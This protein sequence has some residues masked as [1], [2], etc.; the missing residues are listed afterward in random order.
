M[1]LSDASSLIHGCSMMNIKIQKFQLE[2]RRS[3]LKYNFNANQ[4][5]LEAIIKIKYVILLIIIAN[6][7]T[8]YK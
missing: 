3:Q 5:M 2:E 7:L 1:G 4:N 8:Y 6:F